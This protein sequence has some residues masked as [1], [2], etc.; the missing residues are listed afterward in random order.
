MV[1]Q[2]YKKKTERGVPYMPAPKRRFLGYSKF[3]C[4]V[5]KKMVPGM[6]SKRHIT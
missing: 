2:D 5:I 4:D 6:K 1:E 3:Y